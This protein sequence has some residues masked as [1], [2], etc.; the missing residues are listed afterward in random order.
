M[1]LPMLS[2]N[3][4]CSNK[5]EDWQLAD[6]LLLHGIHAVEC[7]N[8]DDE[9][10]VEFLC[11]TCGGSGESSDSMSCR[12]CAGS[13]SIQYECPRCDGFGSVMLDYGMEYDVPLCLYYLK[14]RDKLNSFFK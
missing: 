9:C 10:R 12:T 7:G 13:G 2:R 4:N 6:Y 5:L 11:R 14:Q 1:Y 8:C 3:R